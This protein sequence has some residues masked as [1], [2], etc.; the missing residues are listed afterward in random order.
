MLFQMAP[1]F[2]FGS[3]LGEPLRCI[4]WKGY[5][6]GLW[7]FLFCPESGLDQVSRQLFFNC[8]K[9][10]TGRIDHRTLGN[11]A[12]VGSCFPVRKLLSFKV[13]NSTAFASLNRHILLHR[14]PCFKIEVSCLAD[15]WMKSLLF[16]STRVSL[17]K[18][19]FFFTHRIL[20][21]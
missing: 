2:T 6:N 19:F 17:K 16:S 5:G 15:F 1:L 9:T 7:E 14:S 18:V 20:Y 8:K 11:Y 3:V 10:C 13:F 4:I 12:V 21:L